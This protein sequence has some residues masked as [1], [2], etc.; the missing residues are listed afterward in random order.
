MINVNLI[1]YRFLCA[2]VAVM[3]SLGMQAQVSTVIANPGEDASSGININWHSPRAKGYGKIYYR[4]AGT[5][6]ERP[7]CARAR[8]ELCT[9]YDSMYSKSAAGENIYEHPHFVRNAVNLKKLRPSTLYQYTI[10]GDT[11]VRYFRTAPREGAFRAAIISDF[12]A[13]APL[14]ERQKLAM[15]MLDTL[16]SIN[17]APFDLM[18]HLGDVC[19]WGGSYSFW[20]NLYADAHFRNNTWAGVNGNHDNMDRTNKKNT[21]QF[22]R[23]ANAMP[24]NGYAGEEG[25]CYFFKYGDVL[26]VALNSE[27]M[28]SDEG[29]EKA[30]EWVGRILNENP[31]KW[32]VVMEHYQWF[33]GETGRDSQYPR[34]CDTFDELG[35]DIALGANNHRYV[36]TYPLRGGE[37]VEPGEGTIYI[38]TP[39]A[40][41]ERGVDIEPLAFNHDKIKTRWTEGA[42]TVGAM[43]MDVTPEEITLT[44]YDRTGTPVDT[45]SAKPRR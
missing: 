40:D 16:E 5:D 6:G 11:L 25:V 43:I 27:S 3:I 4:P 29:L 32:V 24:Q 38:Q 36:S 26:F 35:V 39:S 34:W 20:Q 30:R 22:F 17:G 10:L 33:F 7:K 12:H 19:A 44:L 28:R 42:N 9:V 21:N 8:Q 2:A 41:G 18:I 37:V 23:N 45:V 1:I 14:P 13:Y 15:A 31:S